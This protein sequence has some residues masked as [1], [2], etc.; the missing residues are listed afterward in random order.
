MTVKTAKE[1][2]EELVPVYTEILT[3]TDDA[4]SILA[5]AKEAGFNQAMIGKIAKAK[6]A[7]KLGDLQE[8]IEKLAELIEQVS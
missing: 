2:V 5:D 6:A 4:K 3:L 7:E 8:G 1:F